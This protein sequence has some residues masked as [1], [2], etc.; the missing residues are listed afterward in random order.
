MAKEVGHHV[1]RP[2]LP[3]VTG[4]ESDTEAE[5]LALDPGEQTSPEHPKYQRGK[6]ALELLE[7]IRLTDPDRLSA[8]VAS[9]AGNEAEWLPPRIGRFLI[10]RELGRGGHGVVL[11]AIDPRLNRHVALKVPRPEALLTPELR[12][13]F[14]REAEAAA[15]LNH[16]NIVPIFEQGA[17][18]PICYVASAYCPGP[19]LAE[20]LA[21]RSQ[22][23]PPLEAARL[24]RLLADAVQHAHSRGVLHR[25]LKPANVLL[26]PAGDEP[27]SDDGLPTLHIV[28]FGLARIDGGSGQ[29]ASSAIVGTPAYMSPEQAAGKNEEV[30]AASDIYGLGTILYQLLTNQVPFRGRNDLETLQAVQLQEPTPPRRIRAD[31]PRDLEAIC[32]KCL[33]KEPGQRYATAASLYADLGRHVEGHPVEARP[34][35][36]RERLRRWCLRNPALAAVSAA[37]LTLGLTGSATVFWQWRRAEQSLVEVKRQ[38][39]RAERNLHAA[40]DVVDQLLTGIAVDL[41]ELPQTE[42][43]REQLLRKA[44]VINEQFLRDEASGADATRETIDAW[45]RAGDIDVYLGD[46]SAAEGAYLRVVQLSRQL[47]QREGPESHEALS[48][49]VQALLKLSGLP[50]RRSQP[51]KS[52]DYL[53]DALA[54]MNDG[55]SA[56]DAERDLLRAEILRCQGMDAERASDLPQAGRLYQQAIEAVTRQPSRPDESVDRMLTR[57]KVHNSYAIHCKQ[58]QRF[59]EARTHFQKAQ[60]Y[61][62]RL[63]A[64]TPFS[65]L[66]REMLAQ[67]QYNFANLLLVEGDLPGA[68]SR[69]LAAKEEF[70]QLAENFP[71]VPKYRDLWCHCLQSAAL[72]SKQ[73]SQLRQRVV[74]LKKATFLREELLREH[75]ERSDN[76]R[77]LAKGYRNLGR[78]YLASNQFAEARRV[79]IRSI[80]C[81]QPPYRSTAEKTGDA[82][83]DASAYS[84]LAH[85]EAKCQAWDQAAEWYRQAIE[86]RHAAGPETPLEVTHDQLRDQAG[87]AIVT[88]R[89]GELVAGLELL[90]DVEPVSPEADLIA[91][92]AFLEIAAALDGESPLRETSPKSSDELRQAA[93]EHLRQACRVKPDLASELSDARWN[94]LL[95]SL[96]GYQQLLD[97]LQ[98]RE[99]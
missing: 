94:K 24:V 77:M 73:P 7:A 34:I 10:E 2:A 59:Q 93:V 95:R 50:A 31:V 92:E 41:N 37:A 61:L 36:R 98:R 22:P 25:D 14:L 89:G 51:D 66:Y 44:A 54:A 63:Q 30:T 58:I 46:P 69:Y 62:E 12:Q 83:G 16:P 70:K 91:A 21:D 29:T 23:V 99:P 67:N 88:V 3:A 96:P 15:A 17:E 78:D 20:W 27:S 97:D 64:A 76:A 4:A 33:E 85:T 40:R 68:R 90:R 47:L 60:Q 5:T 48:S 72:A 71:R 49:L 75:P 45:R 79:L 84:L 13:R 1:D 86:T 82:E 38:Q 32:L 35:G 28:D 55:P 56:N 42:A 26:T 57:A 6:A 11:L 19:T 81:L 18:G 74:L 9:A 53:G 52:R 87:L 65:T 80:D 39:D 8:L 43:I